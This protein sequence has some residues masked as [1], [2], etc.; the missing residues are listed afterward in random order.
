[1]HSGWADSATDLR[2]IEEL[3]ALIG[4]ALS[5]FLVSILR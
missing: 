2:I 1:L 5:A 3:A 4:K